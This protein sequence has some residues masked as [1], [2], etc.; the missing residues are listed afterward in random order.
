MEKN[1]VIKE[2]SIEIAVAVNATIA[3]F[4]S[5]YSKEYFQER[6]N[7]KDSLILVAYADNQPVGYMVSYKKHDDS[8]FYC[9][10]TGVNPVFRR[11]GILNKLMRR[12]TEWAKQH[13]YKKITIKTRNSRRE[14]LSYLV[15]SGFNFTEVQPQILI[16][17]NRILLEKMVA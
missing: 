9:W 12:L 4:E 3:E 5:K 1:I 2:D 17:D 6:I 11:L 15:K 13:G 16:E 10:M 7:G 14:M 8:S